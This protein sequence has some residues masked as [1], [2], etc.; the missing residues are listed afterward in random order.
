MPNDINC[1]YVQKNLSAYYDKEL[2]ENELLNIQTHLR[3]CITCRREY[4]NIAKMSYRFMMSFNGTE[5]PHFDVDLQ[6]VSTCHFVM[7]HL[8]DYVDKQL[9][10]K[11]V[12]IISEHL[13]NCR[14]CRHDYEEIKNIRK[15]SKWYFSSFKV[16]SSLFDYKDL[17]EESLY[18]SN[19]KLILGSVACLAGVVFL[20][21][22]S[23]V[24]FEP[25]NINPPSVATQDI[26]LNEMS[27]DKNEIKVHNLQPAEIH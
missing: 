22:L 5:I 3:A 20:M 7:E 21:L 6:K 8:N 16:P 9:S 2:D 4:S 25:N 13:L 24:L 10:K 23:A 11:D 1:D 27:I 15:I 19:K 17:L 12:S 14:A 18:A 26:P